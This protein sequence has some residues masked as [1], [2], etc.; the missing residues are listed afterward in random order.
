MEIKLDTMPRFSGPLRWLTSLHLVG[1][2]DLV[3]LVGAITYKVRQWRHKKREALRVGE[4]PV[5]DVLLG[6]TQAVDQLQEEFL[7]MWFASRMRFASRMSGMGMKF[8]A[9]SSITPLWGKCG[10]SSIWEWGIRDCVRCSR[11][12]QPGLLLQGETRS[13]RD[14]RL[15]FETEFPLRAWSRVENNEKA[16]RYLAPK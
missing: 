10:E 2:V 13:T 8:L 7:W 6:V 12:S 3:G 5:E 9:V 1:H 4:V 16:K 11:H 14:P 15:Q